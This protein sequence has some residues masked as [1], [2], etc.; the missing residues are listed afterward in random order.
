LDLNKRGKVGHSYLALNK[1]RCRH[2]YCRCD[3]YNNVFYRTMGELKRDKR[4][5]NRARGQKAFYKQ[6]SPSIWQ[7]NSQTESDK[8]EVE[9]NVSPTEDICMGNVDETN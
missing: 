1:A 4:N 8:R 5:I 6:Y 9:G 7:C 3:I 2:I